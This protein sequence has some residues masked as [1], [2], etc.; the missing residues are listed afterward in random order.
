MEDGPPGRSPM[1]T[2]ALE[3]LCAL[4]MAAMVILLFVQVVGRYVLASPP[5]WTEELARTAFLYVTF[6]GAAV[7][8][9]RRA[10]LRIDAVV[11]WFRP[12]TRHAVSLAARLI[13]IVFL[14]TVLYQGVSFVERLA[15]QP[16]TSLPLSKAWFFAALPVG[17]ALMLIYELV[18]TAQ[19][20]AEIK[21]H[22]S[23]RRD[24]SG[25]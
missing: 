9:A 24:G 23:G 7:A 3:W 25:G 22:R 13:A 17:I 21:A 16:L 8:I 18:R 6:F 10:H 12:R 14:A 20:I 2:R 4:L 19:E 15:V 1:P 5:E 11:S